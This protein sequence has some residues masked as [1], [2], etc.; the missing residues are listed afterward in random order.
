MG[1]E[2]IEQ[3]AIDFKNRKY[4]DGK[5]RV[6]LES[7][8]DKYFWSFVLH[9]VCPGQYDYVYYTKDKNGNEARGCR[10]ILKFLPFFDKEFFA[11]ID[12]DLRRFGIG[13]SVS[14][15]QGVAQTYTYSWENYICYAERVQKLIE[16]YNISEEF[17][18]VQFLRAY[19]NI[20]FPF[21]MFMIYLRQNSIEGFSENEFRSMLPG[22]CSRVDMENNGKLL[23]EKMKKSYEDVCMTHKSWGKFMTDNIRIDVLDVTPDNVYLF[24][25]GHNL[26]PLIVNIGK[27]ILHL[28]GEDFASRVLL[29]PLLKSQLPV[30]V[31]KCFSDVA[32]ILGISERLDIVSQH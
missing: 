27:S 11:C 26:F 22:Q 7:E 30:L 32:Y 28:S 16:N 13:Q 14:A 1:E 5:T 4:I 9:S 21:F 25:R 31:E 6:Y 23:L 18:F 17:D 12:S 10:Q 8:N 24:V 3:Q 2:Y 19:S 29:S 20:V 15:Q